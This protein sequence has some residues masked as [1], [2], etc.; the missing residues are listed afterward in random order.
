MESHEAG[1][2]KNETEKSSKTMILIIVGIIV[3]L[4]AAILIL[5]PDP[6]A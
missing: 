6:G 2:E 3:A 5:H 4:I 1:P